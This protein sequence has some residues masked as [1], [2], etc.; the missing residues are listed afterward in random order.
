MILCEATLKNISICTTYKPCFH[1]ILNI[2]RYGC[3]PVYNSEELYTRNVNH[4]LTFKAYTWSNTHFTLPLF[5]LLSAA[6]LE[7][8]VNDF[9]IHCAI[10]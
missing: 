9:F 4:L 3:R 10:K 1:S 5:P 6:V 2:Y 8:R 7:P